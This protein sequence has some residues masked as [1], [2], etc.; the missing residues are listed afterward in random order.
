MPSPAEALFVALRSRASVAVLSRSCSTGKSPRG[1]PADARVPFQQGEFPGPVKYG[2]SNVGIVEAGPDDPRW[3]S[4]LP[5]PHQTRFVAPTMVLHTIPDG[6]PLA[7]A[8]LAA[9]METALNGVWGRWRTP[10]RPRRSRRWRNRRVPDR[11]VVIAYCWLRRLSRRCAASASRNRRSPR[12]TVHE[13]ATPPRS[14]RRDSRQRFTR[15]AI[16]GPRDRRVGSGDHGDELV[17]FCVRCRCHLAKP[18]RASVDHPLIAGGACVAHSA[19]ALG[20]P[21]TDADG[22]VA[23][24]GAR[25]RRAHFGRERLRGHAHR[26]ARAR[27]RRA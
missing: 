6:V 2:Y 11:V 16:D 25:T 12:R 14:R 13:S 24:D 5:H 17:W 15:R 19:F 20:P 8:V 26:D 3:L 4:R 9:N 27:E 7:R 18:S 22:V 21:A 10:G 23:A 1:I